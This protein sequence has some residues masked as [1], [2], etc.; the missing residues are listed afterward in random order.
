MTEALG[1]ENPFDETGEKNETDEMREEKLAE[2]MSDVFTDDVVESW[3][4]LTDEQ[5]NELL[6]EYYTRAGEELGI[7]ATHVYYEDIHSIYPGTDGYSQGDGT[8]HVDSSLSFADTLNTVTHEMRHQFQSEA[9][10]NPEKF[11][12]ISEETIQRWQ[13]ECD[14]YINGDY[15]LEA[16][17]NQLIEIDA[18]GFAESIVDKY[19][20]EL[21]L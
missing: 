13:Y 11:P 16:Y 9:I 17:A 7:T 20:E 5:R 3:D 4:S 19:S 14:N 12:D 2:I 10:A 6:D 21:S 1:I 18:R 15:D 8:V